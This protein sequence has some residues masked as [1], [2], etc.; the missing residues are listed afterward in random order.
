MREKSLQEK[1]NEYS[2][3][4]TELVFLQGNRKTSKR[5]TDTGEEH[6]GTEQEVADFLFSTKM[7][8]SQPV[9]SS[10]LAALGPYWSQ[11]VNQDG[12]RQRPHGLQMLR[13]LSATLA[14]PF[15]QAPVACSARHG[16]SGGG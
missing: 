13:A 9:P 16:R 1:K 2:A 4:R 14:P 3:T 5:A 15:P 6:E 12:K 10:Q 7:K 11:P 8:W